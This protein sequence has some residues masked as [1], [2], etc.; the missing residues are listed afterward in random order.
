MLYANVLIVCMTG[1]RNCI[2]I[3]LALAELRL[4]CVFVA[5]TFDIGEA[6]EDWDKK[7]LV[8]LLY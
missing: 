3:E 4:V 6:W 5:R 1:P 8:L 2:G 7:Q